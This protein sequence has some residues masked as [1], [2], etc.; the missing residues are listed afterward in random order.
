[1]ETNPIG[2][3]APLTQAEIPGL[4]DKLAPVYDGWA[5]F[6]ESK[7]RKRALE[8]SGLRDGETVLEVAVGTG[9]MFLQ[10]VKQNAHGKNLGIDISD[11]MLKKATRRLARLA[12]DSYQLR[13]GNA[14]DLQVKDASI[15]LLMNSYM[16]DLLSPKDAN[17]V[18]D[19]FARVLNP[20]GRMVIVNMTRG[21][22]RASR[23]YELVSRRSPRRFGGCRGVKLAE[24][25][26]R[27]GFEIVSEEYQ[28]QCFFPSEIIVARKA[29]RT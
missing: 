6:T 28:Q 20:G 3:E 11:G 18:L 16:F 7:A 12:D 8:L 5:F 26:A 29:R 15:D 19:E 2:C 13:N 17:T 10:I 23:V 22:S 24:T 14:L 25:I 9:L 21:R 1:M 4:Y 27:H